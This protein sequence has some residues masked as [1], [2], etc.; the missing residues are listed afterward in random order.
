MQQP[1][2]EQQKSMFA[3]VLGVGTK[4]LFTLQTYQQ[5]PDFETSIL[6]NA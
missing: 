2:K 3:L 6:L 1:I 5:Y 4:S